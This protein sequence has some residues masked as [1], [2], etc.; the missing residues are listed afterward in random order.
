MLHVARITLDDAEWMILQFFTLAR[1]ADHSERCRMDDFTIFFTLAWCCTSRRS[2]WTSWCCTSRGSLWTKQNAWFYNFL[3]YRDVRR[4]DHS[5][6]RR[7]DDFTIFFTLAWCCASRGSLWMT[8]NVWF[9]N[10]YTS[11]MLHVARITLDE[12]EWMILQLLHLRDVARRADH[13]GRC[14][15]YHST[16]FTLAWCCTS[17][18][19]CRMDDFTIFFTLVRRVDHSGRC[20]MDDFTIFLH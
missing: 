7:M 12:A 18:G 13:S 17:R 6:R 5:G 4:A 15:M 14:R 20:R 10:F 16:I 8:Q 9:Y 3:H 2:L 1:R 19:R 11:V